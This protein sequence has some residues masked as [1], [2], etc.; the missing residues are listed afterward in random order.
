MERT[1]DIKL[2]DCKIAVTGWYYEGEKGDHLQPPSGA[3][4][5]VESIKL[6]EGTLLDLYCES[7]G[8]IYDLEERVLKELSQETAADY[9]HNEKI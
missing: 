9:S 8:D 2:G 6:I 3:S 4:F 7:S 1:V 5:E